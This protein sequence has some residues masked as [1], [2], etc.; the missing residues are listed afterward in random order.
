MSGRSCGPVGWFLWVVCTHALAQRRRTHTT[1]T[2]S[3]TR[4]LVPVHRLWRKTHQYTHTHNRE[5]RCARR[6][7]RTKTDYDDDVDPH[8]RY[9]THDVSILDGRTTRWG[10]AEETKLE[11][12][13]RE[14]GVGL[15][16]ERAATL[17]G[18]DA[19]DQTRRRL[20]DS[21]QIIV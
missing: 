19:S 5:P 9:P 14:I 2:R 4:T 18:R 3:H 11:N 17:H 1:D 15:S 21:E 20:T 12:V 13:R 16:A 10:T 8:A 6:E 7:T